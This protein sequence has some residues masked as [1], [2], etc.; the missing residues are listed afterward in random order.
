MTYSLGLMNVP[1]SKIVES[2]AHDIDVECFQC[3]NIKAMASDVKTCHSLVGHHDNGQPHCVIIGHFVKNGLYDIPTLACHIRQGYNIPAVELDNILALPT[4]VHSMKAVYGR[5]STYQVDIGQFPYRTV[6]LNTR[7][8]IVIACCD[9]YM[10]L[11]TFLVEP[12]EIVSKRLL[13]RCR[14][15]LDV[16]HI[17]T[18]KQSVWLFF[19]TPLFQ[20][21]EEVAMLVTT[22]IV[23]VD[24]LPQVQVGSM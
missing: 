13:H 17:T 24:D 4:T 2:I 20:L 1:Q 14:G 19:F 3:A 11:G 5:R 7:S 22:V 9:G 15:L 16:K 6:C 8:R 21:T 23:L 18:H 10:H 12:D